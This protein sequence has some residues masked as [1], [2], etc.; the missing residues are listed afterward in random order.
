[1][2]GS[3]ALFGVS[4]SPSK[5]KVCGF[6]LRTSVPNSLFDGRATPV[7]RSATLFAD[8]SML[9]L[10]CCEIGHSLAHAAQSHGR[11]APTEKAHR[12]AGAE[13]SVLEECLDLAPNALG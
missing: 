5:N 7:T 9:V 12:L 10:L 4:P 1:M 6:L 3:W 8:S 2:S 13:H 11:V